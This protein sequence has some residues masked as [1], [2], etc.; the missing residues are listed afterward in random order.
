MP[1]TSKRVRIINLSAA[2]HTLY[3]APEMGNDVNASKNAT[4]VPDS[5]KKVK[6]DPLAASD[7]IDA[8]IAA[9]MIRVYEPSRA[10]LQDNRTLM[11]VRLLVLEP[12]PGHE[13]EEV[14]AMGLTFKVCKGRGRE[15][16]R[17]SQAKSDVQFINGVPVVA[18]KLYHSTYQ[19][20]VYL[21]Q[22]Q[23][24]LAIER[25]L[26]ADHRPQ[27]QEF[28]RTLL[29]YRLVNLERAKEGLNPLRGKDA[30]NANV[31]SNPYVRRG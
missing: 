24:P 7:L 10:E 6:L 27:V 18:P 23:D 11:P 9:K 22:L 26:A 12:E 8:D 28:G 30:L 15:E 1:P 16:D 17:T 14:T 21:N 29:Q 13:I 5:G 31:T 20:F 2:T 25:Y 3:L 4:F 19:A